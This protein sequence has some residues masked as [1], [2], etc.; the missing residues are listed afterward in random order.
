MLFI[1]FNNKQCPLSFTFS[2]EFFHFRK[3]QKRQN[4]NR[5]LRSVTRYFVGTLISRCERAQAINYVRYKSYRFFRIFKKNKYISYLEIV[6]EY[7]E[8][9]VIK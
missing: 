6:F 3:Y 4:S 8:N 2:N 7:F 5:I 9:V 1:E